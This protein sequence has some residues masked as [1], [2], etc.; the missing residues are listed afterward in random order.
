[1][2][3]GG[4]FG[5]SQLVQLAQ[6]A[7]WSADEAPKIAAIAMAESGGRSGALNDNPATG[8]RSYGLTQV[9]MI[10]GLGPA[11]LKQ[12]G[13]SSNEDLFD[14]ITNLRAAKA[15]RDSQGWN[16][17]SVYRSG[18]HAQYLPGAQQAAAAG[19]DA[20]P[21][22][23]GAD[24]SGFSLAS[25]L[26]PPEQTP[27]A[28]KPSGQGFNIG[29]IAAAGL[30]PIGAATGAQRFAA[31]APG[32]ADALSA[33]FSDS[34]P[35]A[36]A[37]SAIGES[38]LP[39]VGA[40]TGAGGQGGFVARTGN[41]GISTG[42]HLDARWADGRPISAGDLDAFLTIGGKRPSEWGVTSGYG[43]RNA[44]T[45]GASSFHKGVDLGVP[46]GTP[47][48]AANGARLARTLGNLDGA[49][50]TVEVDT[51]KGL[52]RLLHLTPGSSP[53]SRRA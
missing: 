29:A 21:G 35:Q 4:R 22:G 9:N 45:A 1:M 11:R 5:V 39:A 16:A 18:K 6:Q 50:Y 20:T 33:V 7:G 15:I 43:P 23:G 12:F 49:G 34:K 36:T 44:P 46:S 13:L 14:P 37:A 8:D 2:S 38:A 26:A 28:P 30:A 17:W 48:Y 3:Q 10:G 53:L 51:P 41:S 27:A 42:P 47:I 19:G 24:P 31:E 32:I 52:L 40:A 25:L